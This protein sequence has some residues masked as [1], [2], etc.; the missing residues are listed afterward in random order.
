M[1]SYIKYFLCKVHLGW[2]YFRS[3]AMKESN[4]LQ[5]FNLILATIHKQNKRRKHVI[6][7]VLLSKELAVFVNKER[8]QYMMIR[9]GY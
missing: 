4:S 2:H 3:T 5:Q 1:N 8:N 7:I 9:S 6:F